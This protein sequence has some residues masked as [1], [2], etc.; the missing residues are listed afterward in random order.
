MAALTSGARCCSVQWPQPGSMI[1]GRSLGTI[2]DCLATDTALTA[3]M[4]SR[5]PAMQ[6]TTRQQAVEVAANAIDLKADLIVAIGGGS[7]VDSAKI[8]Q[9]CIEHNI[10]DATGLDGYETVSTK[11]GPRPGPF[12]NPK[13]RTIVIPT[14]LSGRRI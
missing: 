5:S 14:T 2:A 3:T 6:H 11:T 4:A 7:L 10:T 13:V 9:M 8:A 12:R 1:A